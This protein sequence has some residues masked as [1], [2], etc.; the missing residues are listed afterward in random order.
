MVVKRAL[1]CELGRD[2]GGNRRSKFLSVGSGGEAFIT[3]SHVH[4]Y[5]L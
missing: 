4:M 1:M 2:E 5:A 3:T